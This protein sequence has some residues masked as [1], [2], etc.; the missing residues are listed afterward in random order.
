MPSGEPRSG[1][2]TRGRSEPG[3][4]VKLGMTPLTD[5]GSHGG[6]P[7]DAFDVVI[8]SLPGF[9]FSGLPPAGPVTRPSSP[10]CGPA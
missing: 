6:D 3:Y 7:D 9:A 8:P 5:P 10:I 1:E 2:L 4:L